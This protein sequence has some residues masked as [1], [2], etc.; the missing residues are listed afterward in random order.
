IAGNSY[1][2]NFS[3]KWS[4]ETAAENFSLFQILAA[5]NPAPMMFFLEHDDF[6]I[7]SCTPERLFSLQ[8]GVMFAQPIKGTR[9]RGKDS[10]EDQVL[11]RELLHDEK[12]LAEH[13]MIVDLLRNDFGRVASF[14][15]VEVRD[16]LR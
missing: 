7:I 6:S 11:A 9:P 12:E 1:Q 4:A 14:G 3:Q 5:G 13:S 8:D 16:F 15:S 10:K 2:V